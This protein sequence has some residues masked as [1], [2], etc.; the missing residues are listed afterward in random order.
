MSGVTTGRGAAAALAV[1][2]AFFF[3]G[4]FTGAGVIAAASIGAEIGSGATMPAGATAAV[5]TAADVA[6]TAAV[7]APTLAAALFEALEAVFFGAAAFAGFSG[8][9]ALAP[10]GV[11]VADAGFDSGVRRLAMRHLLEW[12][13]TSLRRVSAPVQA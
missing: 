11:L 9:G 7:P 1:E 8:A 3:G 13:K 5:A 12:N 4:A 6:G 10:A 2:A